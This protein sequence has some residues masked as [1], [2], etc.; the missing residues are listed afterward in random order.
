MTQITRK[1]FVNKNGDKVQL[2]AAPVSAT[3]GNLAA[4]NS[5]GEIVDSE[6]HPTDFAPA[7]GSTAYAAKVHSH[8]IAKEDSAAEFHNSTVIGTMLDE[9]IFQV[10]YDPTTD[11]PAKGYILLVRY[12]RA[13]PSALV[14]SY[15]N[16]VEQTLISRDGIMRRFRAFND[17]E[18]TDPYADWSSWENLIPDTTSSIT[19]NATEAVT[20][21]AVYTALAGKMDVREFDSIPTQSSTKLLTSGAIY[22]ALSNYSTGSSQSIFISASSLQTAGTTLNTFVANVPENRIVPCKVTITD[23]TNTVCL[24][25]ARWDWNQTHTA[26][27]ITLY[28]GEYI[29]TET[30]SSDSWVGHWTKT[31]IA[32]VL[33]AMGEDDE[34]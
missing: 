6:K 23:S 12:Y 32:S 20:A 17:T 24:G 31:S 9:G 3:A 5:K 15:K 19:E 26:K 10:W 16:Y 25:F 1:G 11:N 8:I 34:S 27:V 2:K 28:I 14:Q 7:T 30:Y 29:F 13:K 18:H 21:G 22:L 4:F 33:S